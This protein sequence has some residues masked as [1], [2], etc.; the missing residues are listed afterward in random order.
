MSIRYEVDDEKSEILESMQKVPEGF[1]QV[2]KE[3]RK[4]A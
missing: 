2:N 1:E 4:A 3:R